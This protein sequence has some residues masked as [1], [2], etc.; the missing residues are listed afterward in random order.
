MKRPF[1]KETPTRKHWLRNNH[2]WTAVTIGTLILG[3]LVTIG[4][5]WYQSRVVIDRLIVRDITQLDA[6]FK[7]IND[8]CGIL[9]FEHEH[10][11]LDFLTV[12]AF[13]GATVGAMN[14][15]NPQNWHGPYVQN[16]PKIQEK[17][18]EIL[19]TNKGY[20][21]VPGAGVTLNNGQVIG[22]DIIFD[23]T[24]DIAAL[25]KDGL[26]SYHDQPLAAAITTVR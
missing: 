14:L 17:T 15:K 18:Y 22:K 25:I 10:N 7:R 3:T 8:E 9:S 1:A 6:I 12:G 19:R 16:T 13:S 24:S 5:Y 20:F 11:Y 4:I 21:L 2:V 23:E 26:L